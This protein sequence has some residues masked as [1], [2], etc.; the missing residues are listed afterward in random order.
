M[1]T[2]YVHMSACDIIYTQASPSHL[3]VFVVQFPDHGVL[4]TEPT[5]LF[6]LKFCGYQDR[7]AEVKKPLIVSTKYTLFELVLSLNNPLQNQQYCQ[8][9]H[10]S[11]QKR[12]V[13]YSYY[14]S[15]LWMS[16]F[17]EDICECLDQLIHT[18]LDY[19][20]EMTVWSYFT[21]GCQSNS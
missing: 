1:Y 15:Y 17:R 2:V 8:F 10:L 14:F 9:W 6:I 21:F 13:H 3:G 4:S 5:R 7:S 19:S 11:V 20:H 18:H 12:E 16:F